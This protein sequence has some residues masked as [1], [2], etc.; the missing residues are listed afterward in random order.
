MRLQLDDNQR[1]AVHY[2][3]GGVLL[4]AAV[5]ALAWAVDA[6]GPAYGRE[7]AVLRPFQQGYLGYRNELA[8]VGTTAGLSERMVLAT[9]VAVG[10]AVAVAALCSLLLRNRRATGV[11]ITRSALTATFAWA[12]YAALMLPLQ[13]SR[14]EDGVLVITQRRHLVGDVPLPFTTEET[15]YAR[16]DVGRIHVREAAPM[17]GCDGKVLLDL[18]PAGREQ[19]IPLATEAGVCP[20][21]RLTRMRNGSEAAAL[22]ER[23][24]R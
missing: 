4:V 1:G 10:V 7:G 22:L 8:V 14:I 20:D 15:R 21:E 23:E 13:E 17:R 11:W 12:M 2:L 16:R 9:V 24:L 3:L 18:F 5:R 6:L 19:G